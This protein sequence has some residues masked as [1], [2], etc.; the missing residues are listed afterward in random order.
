[1][2]PT[3]GALGDI[4]RIAID[5]LH[6]IG[7]DH[8]IHSSRQSPTSSYPSMRPPMSATTVRMQPIRGQGRDSRRD[9]GR[10]GQQPRR[11]MHPLETMLAPSTS[12]I[13]FAPEASTLSPSP[14]PSPSPNPSLLE[15]V[16]SYT[17]VPSHVFPPTEATIPDVTIPETTPLSTNLPSPLPCLEKTTTPHVTLPSSLI[18]HFLEPT[19][20]DVIAPATTIVD[21]I[22]PSPISPLLDATISDITILEIVSPSTTLPSLTPLPIETTMHHTLTHVT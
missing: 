7:K 10:G 20:S 22:L 6:V 16:V 3:L 5:I 1:M 18:S 15:H 21:V 11:S 2:R 9:D 14:L 13:Q 4:H 12:S 8:R 17:T 19:I